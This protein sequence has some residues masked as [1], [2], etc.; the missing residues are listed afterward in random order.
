MFDRLIL[1]FSWLL[2]TCYYS[3]ISYSQVIDYNHYS[4]MKCEGETPSEFL[5]SSL[6]KYNTDAAGLSRSGAGSKKE[7]K[8]QKEFTLINHYKIDEILFSGKVIY[9][10]SV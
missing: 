1:L 5:L 2:F 7:L 3:N 9:G 4:P 8:L 6:N 10:N